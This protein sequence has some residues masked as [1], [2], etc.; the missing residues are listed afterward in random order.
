M[1]IVDHQN[2]RLYKKERKME[3]RKIAPVIVFQTDSL[4]KEERAFVFD[5]YG[6]AARFIKGDFLR[7]KN[8]IEGDP[9]FS[10]NEAN[11]HCGNYEAKLSFVNY[12]GM[13]K[14]EW[15]IVKAFDLREEQTE[16]EESVTEQR[17]ETIKEQD[18]VIAKQKQILS[19]LDSMIEERQ[20]VIDK[21]KP[22]DIEEVEAEAIPIVPVVEPF[23]E[24]ETGKNPFT[25][26]SLQKY[27]FLFWLVDNADEDGYVKMSIANMATNSNYAIG[28]VNDAMHMLMKGKPTIVKQIHKGVY[29]INLEYV[30]ALSRLKRMIGNCKMSP[31]KLDLMFWLANNAE[32][33][34]LIK[35]SQGKIAEESNVNTMTVNEAINEL[36]L[37]NTLRKI[38][39]GV[40]KLRSADKKA[41]LKLQ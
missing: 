22:A 14:T 34:N 13:E 2:P 39:P 37:T 29:R 25:E 24:N 10:Y 12:K 40:Y 5:D 35:A 3:V 23:I 4:Y 7:E 16:N 17:N 20:K 30:D 9:R 32:S 41:L 27:Q 28:T 18:E 26:F 36:C 38:K 33:N 6:Q 19:Y 8:R 11:S 1:K 21:T 15:R 31:K